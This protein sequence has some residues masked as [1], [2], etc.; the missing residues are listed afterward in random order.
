MKTVE[1]SKRLGL[2]LLIEGL[3]IFV[4]M[5]ILGQA[6]NWPDILGEPANVVLPLIHQHS[7]E[8]LIGY[9]SYM[10]YSILFFPAI[11][12]IAFNVSKEKYLEPSLWIA[13]AFG[14]LS[15]ATR[16]IGIIRWL[17]AMPILANLYSAGDNAAKESISVIFEAINAYGGSIG[18]DLGV[19]IFASVSV[20]LISVYILKNKTLPKWTGWFGTAAAIAIAIPALG[21]FG[22]DV[23]VMVIASVAVVQFWFMF[24]GVYLMFRK[25]K[26]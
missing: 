4:P 7:S 24:L 14:A 3:L 2:F 9:F 18:E 19:S 16:S 26:V 21:I 10:V 25:Y 11:A 5:I 17:S 15:G 22:I 1:N 6:I 13:A 8:T 23:G 20:A 12:L